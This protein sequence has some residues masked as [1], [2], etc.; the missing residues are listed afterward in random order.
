MFVFGFL[1][2]RLCATVLAGVIEVSPTDISGG[3][4]FQCTNQLI[5]YR[6]RPDGEYYRLFNVHYTQDK[7]F[8]MENISG[9]IKSIAV[10]ASKE[11][12]LIKYKA[13]TARLYVKPPGA[14]DPLPIT[15]Q[16]MKIR[17]LLKSFVKESYGVEFEKISSYG[18]ANAAIEDSDTQWPSQKKLSQRYVICNDGH[19]YHHVDRQH[20]YKLHLFVPD[21]ESQEIVPDYFF[22][23]LRSDSQEN[24]IAVQRR[25]WFILDY[26]LDVPTVKNMDNLSPDFI[27]HAQCDEKDI[28]TYEKMADERMPLMHKLNALMTTMSNGISLIGTHVQATYDPSKPQ[29]YESKLFQAHDNY[30]NTIKNKISKDWITW[31]LEKYTGKQ[32]NKKDLEIENIVESFW[33]SHCI[34]IVLGL[35]SKLRDQLNEQGLLDDYVIRK[36]DAKSSAKSP[37]KELKPLAQKLENIAAELETKFE[38]IMKIRRNNSENESNLPI[39]DLPIPNLDNITL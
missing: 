38:K 29:N 39:S 9:P 8:Y 34:S 22:Y 11:I 32:E 5:Y 14:A 3:E 37:Y 7:L 19:P 36:L 1:L 2:L 15:R 33:T 21:I 31:M 12:T 26:S 16:R 10:D 30:K 6:S 23:K 24:D 28:S 27:S 35:Y 17:S 13:R 25:R 20:Y 4:Y 18:C